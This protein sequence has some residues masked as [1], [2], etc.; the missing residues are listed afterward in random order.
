[1]LKTIT[2]SLSHGRLS[3]REPFVIADN[4]ELVLNFK[5][6]YKLDELIL[7]MAHDSVGGGTYN[8]TGA[9]FTVPRY[10]LKAGVLDVM[11]TL[12]RGGQAV[13]TWTVEPIIL[14]ELDEGLT[15]H[16]ELDEVLHSIRTLSTKITSLQAATEKVLS[17][18]ANQIAA[19]Q[20]AVKKLQNDPLRV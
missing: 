10:Y 15:G 20:D 7:H 14:K 12:V 2:L 3:D 4:D 19:L 13:K 18:H 16:A 6:T 1:M 8:C 17:A 11:V 9:A 5:S